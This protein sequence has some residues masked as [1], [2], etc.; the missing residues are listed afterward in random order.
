MHD[1]PLADPSSGTYPAAR[2]DSLPNCGRNL[3]ARSASFP[4]RE[5][6][7]RGFDP[8]QILVRDVRIYFR[9]RDVP[10][11]G[12]FPN[13]AKVGSGFRIHAGYRVPSK[14]MKRKLRCIQIC[15]VSY[16]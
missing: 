14:R 10:V 13:R 7:K 9:G 1:P 16:A 15:A 11:T 4:A 8:P 2:K 3:I 12:Q 5:P 6:F